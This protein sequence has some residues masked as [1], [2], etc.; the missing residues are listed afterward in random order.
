[1][2]ANSVRIGA[3]LTHSRCLS[4]VAG[5]PRADSVYVRRGQERSLRLPLSGASPQITSA[6]ASQSKDGSRSDGWLQ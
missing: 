2:R 6:A 4:G 3:A 5:G 1:M